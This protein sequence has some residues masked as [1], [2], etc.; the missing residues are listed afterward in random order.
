MALFDVSLDTANELYAWGWRLSLGGAVV[1]ALGVAMLMLGTRVR[2]HDFEHQVA[3]LNL[4]AG[5]ARERA[6]KL[7]EKAA[8]LEKE[9]NEAKAAIADANARALE[10]QVALERF[11]APRTLSLMQQQ[12]L[13]AKLAPFAGTKV[14]VWTLPTGSPDISSLADLIANVLE[15]AKWVVGRATSLSGKSFP[16]VIV[17]VRTGSNLERQAETIVGFLNSL[18]IAAAIAAPFDNESGLMPASNM[19]SPNNEEPNMVVVVGSKT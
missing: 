4:E 5:Q 14:R 3:N 12:D 9:S 7:E 11:R 2:D 16:G 13:R 15:Q 17:A 18:N 1:T 6:G 8:E 19:F 10:A